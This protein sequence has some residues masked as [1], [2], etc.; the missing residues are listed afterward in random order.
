[1]GA[2]QGVQGFLLLGDVPDDM[3]EAADRPGRAVDQ[4]PFIMD[5]II[6]G[7]S[8]GVEVTGLGGAVDLCGELYAVPP[9]QPAAFVFKCRRAA[10]T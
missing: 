4:M 7:V 9:G 6:Q 2:G 3:V 5:P 10:G 8:W 1:M